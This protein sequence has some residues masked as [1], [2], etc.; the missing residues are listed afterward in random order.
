MERNVEA[1]AR[2]YRLEDAVSFASL[3]CVGPLS[4]QLGVSSLDLDALREGLRASLRAHGEALLEGEAGDLA[5]RLEEH[6]SPRD[7]WL[8]DRFFEHTFY[9]VHDENPHWSAWDYLFHHCAKR[10]EAHD[11]LGLPAPRRNEVLAQY[12]HL[13]DV[14]EIMAQHASLLEGMGSDWDVEV[15][16]R[17]GWF[18]QSDN[19]APPRLVRSSATARRCQIF[20][21]W[22][23]ARL[24]EV[25]LRDVHRA[26]MRLADDLTVWLPEP[27]RDLRSLDAA[28]ADPPESRP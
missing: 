20:V 4:P 3:D 13:C 25:E 11:A 24:S 26:A 27:L 18:P 19:G 23:V 17:R 16:V 12:V 6:L 5:A 1:E 14:G 2:A 7:R 15:F 9:D 22:L 10:A 8:F 28:I 21:R